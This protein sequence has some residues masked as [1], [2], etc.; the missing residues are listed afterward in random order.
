MLTELEF[1][2]NRALKSRFYDYADYMNQM[3]EMNTTQSDNTQDGDKF[4]FMDYLPFGSKSISGLIMRGIGQYMPERDPRQ[5]ALNQFYDVN[6]GTIQ[7]GLMKDYNPVSGGLFG[8]PINYG[9]QDAYQKRIDTINKT[10]K[11]KS[12]ANENYDDTE[13]TNRRNQ[14]SLNKINESMMLDNVNENTAYKNELGDSYSGG[15]TTTNVAGQNITSYN[16]PFDPGG[17]EK[18]GGFIDGSNRRTDYM[19]GGRAGY[20]FGGRIG[21][22]GGGMDM[23]NEENQAQSAA[24]GTGTPGP[25]DTGGEGGDNPSD[26]SDTQFSGGDNPPTNIGNPFGYED[27][28]PPTNVRNPFGYQDNIMKTVLNNRYKTNLEEDIDDPIVNRII[29]NNK[30]DKS[31]FA[32]FVDHDNFTDRLK[33]SKIPNYHQ[34]GGFDFMARFPGTNPNLAKGLASAYQNI[35]EYGRAVADGFGGVT[36]EDA[37]KKA[38]EESRLNAVGIDAFSDPNSKTY[39]TYSDGL[40]PEIMGNVR[41]AK[42]GLASIL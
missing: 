8:T 41:M 7:S 2:K 35:F 11:R 28:A 6:N 29:E 17:G 21:F 19:E 32:K 30:P 5:T 24:I 14:L 20:F 16:D 31:P 26:D 12:A 1:N 23:G 18:D 25:G 34:L 3:N 36:F 22:A 4:N 15:D 37:G 42:G 39:K 10:I 38:A 27:N 33:E 9:L 40:I 13:L